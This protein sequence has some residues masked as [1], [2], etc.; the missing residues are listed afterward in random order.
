MFDRIVYE[1]C[2][3]RKIYYSGYLSLIIKYVQVCNII[4]HN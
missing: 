4:K 1:M 3:P 2:V